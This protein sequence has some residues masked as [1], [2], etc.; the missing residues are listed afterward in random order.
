VRETNYNGSHETESNA[1]TM[2][3]WNEG[4]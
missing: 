1:A 2:T 4:T 3:L